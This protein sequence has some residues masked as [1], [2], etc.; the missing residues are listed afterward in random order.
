MNFLV[1]S[2]ART[3][4]IYARTQFRVEES[5]QETNADQFILKNETKNEK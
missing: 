5:L 1:C 3:A 4:T 2:M